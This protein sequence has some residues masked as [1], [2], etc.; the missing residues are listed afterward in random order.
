M[1]QFINS[2][3]GIIKKIIKAIKQDKIKFISL[4]FIKLFVSLLTLIIVLIIIGLSM[5]NSLIYIINILLPLCFLIGMDIGYN[6]IILNYTDSK[7]IS[8]FDLF[9][10]FYLLPKMIVLYCCYLIIPMILL[11]Y[12]TFMIYNNDGISLY[13]ILVN[14]NYTVFQ[15]GAEASIAYNIQDWDIDNWHIS[16]TNIIII[17]ILSISFLAFLCKFWTI[18]IIFIDKNY[19]INNTL[20]YSYQINKKSSLRLIITFLLTYI[21]F[22][23]FNDSVR[24][25]FKNW[26]GLIFILLILSS[27]IFD[28]FWTAYYRKIAN[29]K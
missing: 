7:R 1:K 12:I 24:L 14:S 18:K 29:T 22:T 16:S 27:V 9:Q 15:N 5:D 17:M 2:L 4:F 3:A 6:K 23:T 20:Q 8:L 26:S 25:I 13:N 28:L 19:S 11:T 21:I 10:Y